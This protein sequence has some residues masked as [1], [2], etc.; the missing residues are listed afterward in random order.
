MDP[1]E[2]EFEQR[3]RDSIQESVAMSYNPTRFTEMLNT[4]G[5]LETARRLVA[6]GDLQDGILRIVAMGH[7]ELAMES[8]MLEPRFATLF[9]QGQLDAARW[10]L[11]QAREEAHT[12]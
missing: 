7:A 1:L 6:S 3:L 2:A 11:E 8:I 9:T 5:G 12:C 4:L 10:R